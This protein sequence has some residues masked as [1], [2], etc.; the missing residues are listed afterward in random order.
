MAA[1]DPLAML[2]AACDASRKICGGDGGRGVG[3]AGWG[4]RI[5][6]LADGPLQSGLETGL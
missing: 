4:Q 3:G 6:R 5:A 2:D 1:E